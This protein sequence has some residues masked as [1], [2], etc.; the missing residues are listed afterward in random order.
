MQ[1]KRGAVERGVQTRK[2]RDRYH[3]GVLALT[4]LLSLLCETLNKH[5]IHLCL[6]VAGAPGRMNHCNVKILMLVRV[7]HG[8]TDGGRWL[9]KTFYTNT[10]PKTKIIIKKVLFY[11]NMGSYPISPVNSLE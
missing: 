4:P 9:H 10:F 6:H 7:T 11:C 8:N 3:P 2:R 1:D 5:T